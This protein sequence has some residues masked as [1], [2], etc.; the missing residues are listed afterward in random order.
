[1]LGPFL[2]QIIG[3]PT[4]CGLTDARDEAD[5]HAGK[6]AA[7]DVQLVAAELAEIDLGEARLSS[8]LDGGVFTQCEE[9]LAQAE[10][11]QNGHRAVQTAHQ[12]RLSKGQHLHGLNGFA[13]HQ[14][15]D[16][17]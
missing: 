16:Y 7:E 4:G 1:M 11:T 13:A 10:Q 12:R 14:R 17:A 8:D 5:P 9:H 15:Q 2:R 6:Q 3:E